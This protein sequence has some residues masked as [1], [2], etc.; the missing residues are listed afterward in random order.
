VEKERNIKDSID[1]WTSY[2]SKDFDSYDIDKICVIG[3]GYVGFPLAVELNKHYDVVGFDI[4]N[5]RI[6]QLRNKNDVT[7]EIST[8]E[9]NKIK[10]SLTASEV[11][12][13]DCNVYIITVPT[14]IDKFKKPDLKSLKLASE[15]VGSVISKNNLVIYESTVYPG[16]TREECIPI[17]EE[18]SNLNL[19]IDFLCGYSPERINPGDKINTIK[20]ITKIVSG[21]N[22]V[23]LELVNQIYSK[24][25]SDAETFRVSSI[26]VAEAAK[27]IE[28]T[29][30]DLNIAFVNE[31]S[32][33]FDKIGIN[34][35]EVI[36]AAATKWN[37]LPFKPG[38]VGGH[39]I[40]VDSYY[41]T[42]KSEIE[43]YSPEMIL[44]GRKL[45]DN[46]GFYI[47]KKVK[48]L[49]IEKSMVL[50]KSKVLILGFSFKENCPDIRNSK[51]IDIITE[52]KV[53]QIG[54]DLFDPWVLP[55]KVKEIYD[56]DMTDKSFLQNEYDAIILAVAHKEFL[57]I[58]LDKIS[59]GNTVIF[60]VKSFFPKDKK[61]I[62]NQL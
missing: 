17:L 10:I 62:I 48:S 25:L 2:H 4:N 42:Y 37:F 39:C 45:N 5:D 28:N 30:R 57:K 7:G 36:D 49:M 26:E 32:L 46:M 14:P 3:L 40:G 27:V 19:N 9:L 11:E 15:L 29:Q 35:K 22:E 50:E 55:E 54:I 12:I 47:G 33:I 23:A 59:H 56:L 18:K 8:E 43:G 44:A 13:K 1:R 34:T 21:S 16:C 61:L 53:N 58:D 38:L 51:V 24:I 31:L 41:L 6:K 20:N 60:D 52:L